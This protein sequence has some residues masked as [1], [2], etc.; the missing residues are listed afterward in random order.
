MK[1]NPE[2]RK[3]FGKF[4]VGALSASIASTFPFKLFAS[5]NSSKKKTEQQISVTINPMAV[6]RT[7]K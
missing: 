5:T 6:K 7:R 2:R 3:F 4:G 1:I